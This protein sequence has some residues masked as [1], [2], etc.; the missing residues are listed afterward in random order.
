MDETIKQTIN[1]QAR[2]CYETIGLDYD[3][4]ELRIAPL[5]EMI[6]AR[7]IFVKEL[8]V[9]KRLTAELAVDCIRQE[10]GFAARNYL[11]KPNK[12]SGFIYAAQSAGKLFG[13][14]FT[15]TSEPTAR[16][17]FSAAHELAHYLLHFLPIT[18]N[19]ANDF[20][21][22]TEGISFAGEESDEIEDEYEM[23]LVQ[24]FEAEES[25]NLSLFAKT[26]DYERE[27][28]RFAAELL[29]PRVACIGLAENYGR[30][31]GKNKNAVVRRLAT[32]FLVSFDAM[33]RRLQDL[34]FYQYD[35][36]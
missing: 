11:Q 31:F 26:W 15:E 34:E 20:L 27:A 33:N 29:M 19:R 25:H 9:E 35:G 18:E 5:F 32:D 6:T 8:A 4:P 1:N 28:D 12:L 13:C 7:P 10:M 22:M 16:R 21:V 23:R 17:R 24:D 14:I 3:A 30:K 2:A 36:N